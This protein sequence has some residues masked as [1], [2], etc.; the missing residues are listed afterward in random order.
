MNPLRVIW[1]VG[2]R[3]L[4]ERGRSRAFILG[5]IATQALI[6]GSFFLQAFVAGEASK[7]S[8]GTVG[9]VPSDVRLAITVVADSLDA[10]LAITPYSDLAAATEALR[11]EKVGA[12]LVGPDVSPGDQGV[13]ELLVKDR[14]D[15]RLQTIVQAAYQSLG[16]RPTPVPSLHALE[17][18]SAADQTAFL[19]ANVAVVLLFVS[20]FTF[21][22]W[23]LTGVVEEKQSRV[24]E[25]VLAT[26]RPRELLMGKVLGIGVLGL[27]QLLLFVITGLVVA[28]VTGKLTLPTTTA[29]TAL[30]MLAWF[31]IGYTL[32]STMF[33][34]LGA[35]ANRV[36]D[37][38][39]ASMPVMFPAI[40]SYL[41][42]LLVVTNDPDGTI[43]IVTT[44]VPFSAPIVV[45][46]RAA[47]GAIAPWEILL[48][49]AITIAFTY[50]LFV[51]GGRVYAGAVL[52][53]GGQMK[54][55]DAWRLAGRG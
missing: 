25:V 3:E 45:P 10:D 26:V 2:L 44:Y 28:G 27:I 13:G 37:A 38:S 21:G 46:L 4:L 6:I 16:Q 24:V 5:L 11:D 49:A 48:S 47:L 50:L 41:L 23:V 33:A 18:Q 43:A 8:L 42:A 7:V 30:L 32:Y 35:L 19:L 52:G 20:I 34:T 1:L 51:I 31:A 12:V 55:R 39:N 14:P 29:P 40:A 17:P 36:E 22:Y 54:L 9:S 53:T 15:A